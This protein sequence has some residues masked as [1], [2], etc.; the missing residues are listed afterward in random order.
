MIA[1]QYSLC[2]NPTVARGFGAYARASSPC[3][4][5]AAAMREPRAAGS[6]GF[7][8]QAIAPSSRARSSFSASPLRNM[9]G[10][11][12]NYLSQSLTA[13]RAAAVPS[14]L[15][16]V[17]SVRQIFASGEVAVSATRLA[18]PGASLGNATPHE[19]IS[20]ELSSTGLSFVS[21]DA[22]AFRTDGLVGI[23]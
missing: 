6:N 15:P 3:G 21:S 11:C 7:A 12:S 20:L 19:T 9:S 8:R 23:F 5:R 1:N 13:R 18:V 22:S 10:M 16:T 2:R 4:L 14:T 17:A